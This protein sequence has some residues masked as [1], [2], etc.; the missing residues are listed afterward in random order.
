MTIITSKQIL[1]VIT[2][3]NKLEIQQIDAKTTFLN[4]GLDEEVYI[5]HTE[6]F[7]IN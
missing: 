2:T 6:G 4:D 5:E 7:V 1:K 3:I